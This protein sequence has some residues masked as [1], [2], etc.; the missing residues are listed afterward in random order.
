MLLRVRCAAPDAI[1]RNSSLIGADASLSGSNVSA[2]RSLRTMRALRPLRAVS[3]WQGMKVC[4]CV[5][6]RK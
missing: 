3:R 5:T 1:L 6:V 4:A 2:L